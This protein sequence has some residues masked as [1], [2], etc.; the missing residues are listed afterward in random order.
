MI[1]KC[2]YCDDDLYPDDSTVATVFGTA[3]VECSEENDPD[4]EDF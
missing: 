2:T 1:D 4:E 3:H